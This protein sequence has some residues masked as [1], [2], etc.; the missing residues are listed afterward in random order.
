[1]MMGPAPMMRTECMSV[2]FGIVKP[3][4]I[5]HGLDCERKGKVASGR[6]P[7]GGGS[8]REWRMQRF[9]RGGLTI[10]LCFHDHRPQRPFARSGGGW[11]TFRRVAA[12]EAFEERTCGQLDKM[13]GKRGGSDDERRHKAI[14]NRRGQ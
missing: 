8:G 1:M 2:R 9:C 5:E 13:V 3:P 6:G 4:Q 14:N 11:R 12:A 7:R 10:G